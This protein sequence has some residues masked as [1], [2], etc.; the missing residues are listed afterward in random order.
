ME[1]EGI[2]RLKADCRETQKIADE[3]D[4]PQE[5]IDDEIIVPAEQ[6]TR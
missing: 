2:L 3:I 1:T 5:P 6:V 4:N